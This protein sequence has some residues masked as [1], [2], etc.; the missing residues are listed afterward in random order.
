MNERH[1]D[2]RIARA[3][4]SLPVPE[5]GPGFWTVLEG[6]LQAEPSYLAGRGSRPRRVW[7]L[8]AAVAAAAAVL[9]GALVVGRGDDRR[10]V[11]VSSSTTTT[12]A[13]TTTVPVEQGAVDAVDRFLRALGA[14]DL[15]QAAALLGPRSEAYAVA[16][17][18]S[19]EE[20]LRPAEEGYG[21]WAAAEDRRYRSISVR[22]GDVVV[23]VEGDRASEGTVEYRTDAIP[24]RHAE[25]ADAWFVEP[26]AF[27]PEV[28][29]RIELVSPD[30]AADPLRL[31]PGARVEV[32]VPA[33]GTA[34]FSLGGSTPAPVVATAAGTV[35]WEPDEGGRRS[36]V[37]VVVFQT[38]QTFTAF[39]RRATIG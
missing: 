33:A 30:P 18:G 7:R 23:V 3:L 32:A 12:T 37:L 1:R 21:A 17:A 19:V 11:T 36:G 2:D 9:V 39:A 26:W 4:G 34:W 24:A 13:V 20:L 27:D 35:R 25:S 5:H 31:A 8:G 15:D 14:G 28:G 22:P 38:E 16:V 10:P 6:E 29:G